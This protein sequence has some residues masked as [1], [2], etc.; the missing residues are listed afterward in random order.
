[1]L[2]KPDK[3][4]LP[5]KA[6][7]CTRA[8]EFPELKGNVSCYKPAEAEALNVTI[9]L[10]TQERVLPPITQPGNTVS[11]LPLQTRTPSALHG[12]PVR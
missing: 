11:N 6:G 9:V 12:Q 1:M 2:R 8:P 5:S 10:V 3:L 4:L 7:Y